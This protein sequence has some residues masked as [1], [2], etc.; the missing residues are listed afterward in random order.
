MKARGRNIRRNREESGYGLTE[1]ANR[2]GISASYLSRVERDQA[3]PSPTVLR[4]IAEQLRKERARRA[5]IAEIT[6]DEGSDD[7]P[8]E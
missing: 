7:K 4:R 5:A 8:P 2:I 3:N 6:E 1:F